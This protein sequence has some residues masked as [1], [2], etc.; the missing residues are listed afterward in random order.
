M[1]TQPRLE[2]WEHASE[3]PLTA[4]ALVFLVAYAAPI[5]NP[6]LSPDLV[7]AL[8]AVTWCAW[9]LLVV[10][11]AIRLALATTEAGS[12][13]GTSSTCSS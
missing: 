4:A 12:S 13:C 2:R 7:D 3:W 8:R 9:A 1:S 5:L 10:D 6:E 11:Y